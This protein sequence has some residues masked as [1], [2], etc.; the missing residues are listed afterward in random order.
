[1][2]E[3]LL[4]TL[5][6]DS[7]LRMLWAGFDGVAEFQLGSLR[8]RLRVRDSMIALDSGDEAAAASVVYPPDVWAAATNIDRPAGTE[9]LTS[10]LG[11]GAS[12]TGDWERV[13]SPYL[14]ALSRV[15]RLAMDAESGRQEIRIDEDPFVETDDPVGRYVRYSVGDDNYRV[16]YEQAGYGEVPVLFMHTAGADGRQYRNVLANPSLQRKYTMITLDLP[17]HGKSVPPVGSAWWNRPLTFTKT[18]M[19]DLITGFI[20]AVGMDRPIF[21]GCSVGGQLASDLC[22]H[23]PEAIRGAV[24]VNG[25]YDMRALTASAAMNARF[26]D[27]ATSSNVVPAVMY[28]LSSPAAPEDFRRELSWIYASNQRDTYPAD[29]DYYYFD[30][31]LNEDGHLIDTHRT[32]LTMLTGEY[33]LSMFVPGHDGAA[34]AEKIPGA[35]HRVMKGLSHF[36]PSDDPVRFGVELESALDDIVAQTGRERALA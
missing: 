4:Q 12:L 34:I 3:A 16:Y 21:V 28:N 5:T 23:H 8:L 26:R 36:A 13:V 18:I 19:L 6:L 2:R 24:G 14:A 35:T 11:R 33:D 25:L 20:G 29:C 31:D 1:M 7:E 9:S 15:V 10:A 17:Y 30:H 32:P 22:A 27:L